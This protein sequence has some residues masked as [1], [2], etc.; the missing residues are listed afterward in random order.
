MLAPLALDAE[1]L[2]ILNRPGT[3]W[4]DAVMA[5]ASRRGVLL[6]LALAACVYLARRSP[7]RLFA[8]ALLAASIGAADLFAVRLVKPLVARVRP[9]NE[10]PPRSVSPAGCGSGQSFPSAHAADT[11]AAATVFA[12]AAPTFAAVGIAVALL[13]GVS[14]IYLG[15]HWPTDVAAGWAIGWLVGMGV[16]LLSRL[17]YTIRK[18]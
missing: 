14:R 6:A 12:W 1:L 9:C 3:P 10:L 7:Q 16:I 13:S 11:A 8:A 17:R 2:A 5:G 15:V 4:L 18:N